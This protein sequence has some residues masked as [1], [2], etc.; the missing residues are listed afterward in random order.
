MQGGRDVVLKAVKP[1]LFYFRRGG[2]TR[3]DGGS[4]PHQARRLRG[5]RRFQGLAWEGLYICEHLLE[6]RGVSQA[7][8]GVRQPKEEC[9]SME[10]R[11]P[12]Q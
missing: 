10:S 9:L 2:V 11:S 8:G 3:G 4:F 6:Q 1:F 5:K 12:V 7:L